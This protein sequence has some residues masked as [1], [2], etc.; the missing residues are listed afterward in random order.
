MAFYEKYYVADNCIIYLYGDMQLDKWLSE[1]EVE[2]LNDLP[3]INEEVEKIY[4]EKMV[5][6][7]P[8]VP[9]YISECY[10]ADKE[11]EQTLMSLSFVIG[12]AYDAELRLAF[13]LLEH[14]LLR[15]SASPLTK[16]IV[17]DG[18]LGISLGEG[19]YDTSR[20]QS[21][22]S[23]SLKG[24]EK[25][26]GEK[27]EKIVLRELERLAKEGIDKELIEA[28]LHTLAFELKEV[29]AS[30]DPVGLQ[31]SEMIFNSY[32]YGGEPFTHLKYK[33]H[34]EKIKK[35][36]DKGY[37][38]TLIKEYFLD[39][40][41]R[42]LTILNP[43]HALAEEEQVKLE[44]HLMAYEQTLTKEKKDLLIAVNEELEEMHMVQNSEEKIN[45]LPQLKKEDLE[46][47]IV[48]IHKKQN[49][50]QIFEYHFH[51]EETKGIAYIHLLF[52]TQSVKEEDL[53]YL[54]ILGHL[55]SYIGTQDMNYQALENKINRLTGGLNCSLQAYTHLEQANYRP[56]FK[57]TSKVLI[58]EIVEWKKLMTAILKETIFIEKDKIKEILGN[59]HYEIARSFE[60]APEY[61][62][63]RRVF[64]FFA[65]AGQYEDVVSGI[66][67]YEFM[68]GF[69]KEFD[70]Q[71]EM[72][73]HKVNAVYKQ[74][75][76]KQNLMVFVTA[77]QEEESFLQQELF[78]LGASLPNNNYPKQ[79][80]DLKLTTQSEAYCTM[81]KVEAVAKGF[82]FKDAGFT[83]HGAM[84]VAAHIIE[85]I[86][87][88]N[89]I[90]LQGGA[91]GCDILISRDGH[92]VTCSYC[93]PKL[94][95]TL[96]TFEGIGDFLKNL[97]LKE[98]ELDRYIIHTIGTMQI[99][100]SM[101]Q[102]SER[103]LTY[104][105]CGMTTLQLENIIKEVLNTDMQQIQELAKLFDAFAKA[106]YL[107]VVGGK[108]QIKKHKKYFDS[109][110]N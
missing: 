56:Y 67:F 106:P 23:I 13:E 7:A 65:P 52:D 39:N 5:Q 36:K 54:G 105:L 75:M 70:T 102:K 86:Y 58:E 35:Y 16:A 66:R 96:K 57:I 37:F 68:K 62:A 95:S 98:S 53:P 88:W 3:K 72:I 101:E 4:Y 103:A 81:Q 29:D 26:Q 100:M 48:P 89:R 24:A 9:M 12:T 14:M 27:F 109:I 71:Y 33:S 45:L 8:I 73:M 78:D 46:I 92:V 60:G 83:Y 38:E 107:C 76:G 110:I 49:N 85:S 90:R 44:Q 6:E 80:Y 51:E 47:N 28:A 2:C 61:R 25:T 63:T 41:H 84:E 50:D 21:V 34:V 31:Y 94:G 74:I 15:S 97:Q 10:P 40:K 77:P 79:I 30:Y 19:G 104:T 18:K 87:L 93:D 91:Y 20:F 11:E 55:L 32:L 108:T 43:S 17:V 42:V 1:L 59:V 64:A 69:M 22:F 99:P 82:S